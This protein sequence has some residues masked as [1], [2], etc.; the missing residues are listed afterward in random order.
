MLGG[1]GR[2]ISLLN[3]KQGV[4]GMINEARLRF[5]AETRGRSSEVL[6]MLMLDEIRLLNLKIDRLVKAQEV[7]REEKMVT[8]E[9]QVKGYD[10]MGRADLLKYVSGL[11]KSGAVEGVFPKNWATKKTVELKELLKGVDL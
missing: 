8:V 1:W 9:P 10:K 4:I 3:T 7:I 2:S 11:I 6:L 5:E